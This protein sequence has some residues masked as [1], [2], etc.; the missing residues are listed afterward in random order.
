MASGVEQL[1]VKDEMN[2][3]NVD[4]LNL[5]IAQEMEFVWACQEKNGAGFDK[6]L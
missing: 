2:Q 3:E 4:T 6:C 5:Q 1:C